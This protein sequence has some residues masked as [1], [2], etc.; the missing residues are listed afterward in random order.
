MRYTYPYPKTCTVCK[1]EW[2]AKN[3]YQVVRNVTCGD[4]ECRKARSLLGN[5]GKKGVSPSRELL[6]FLRSR[7]GRRNP[8]WRG[9]RVGNNGLHSWVQRNKPKPSLCV[10]CNIKKPIDLANI[11]QEYKRD[12]NDFKW[13]CRGCHMKEDGRINNLKQFQRQLNPDD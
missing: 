13:V 10:D 5:L 9:N 1:K 2:F 3:R 12:I 8:N 4:I 6:K 7:K 11:S